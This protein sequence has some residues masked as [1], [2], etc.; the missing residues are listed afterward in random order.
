M[1]KTI[2]GMEATQAVSR[3]PLKHG[4]EPAKPLVEAV[5]SA[6][7]DLADAPKLPIDTEKFAAVSAHDGSM[8]E[9]TQRLKDN[10]NAPIP[11]CLKNLG[12]TS[13][14]QLIER[15]E[16][17]DDPS[18]RAPTP[19]ELRAKREAEKQVNKAKPVEKP[20]PAKSSETTAATEIDSNVD[21][22]P[23][24]TIEPDKTF[25]RILAQEHVARTALE[26][27]ELATKSSAKLN[28]GTDEP[29]VKPVED[30]ASNAVVAE[31][32]DVLQQYTFDTDTHDAD[33]RIIDEIDGAVQP[34]N[35]TVS[36]AVKIVDI[37]DP[38][39]TEAK[40][41]VKIDDTAHLETQ[42]HPVVDP[43][44][45][46]FEAENAAADTS[47]AVDEIMTKLGL[48]Y[49]EPNEE[50]VLEKSGLMAEVDTDNKVV[51]DPEWVVDGLGLDFE[52]LELDS[53][54]VLH[55][56]ELGSA[57]DINVSLRESAAELAETKAET[58]EPIDLLIELSSYIK[59]LEPAK[60][61][62]AETALKSLSEALEASYEKTD[63]G[64]ESSAIEMKVI[65]HIFVEL[66][67]A[68]NLDYE[69][70]T[71]KKLMQELF[72]PELLAWIT[73]DS[74]PSIDQLNYS[75]T[76]EYKLAS[77]TSLFSRLLQLIKQR[78]QPYL[79]LGNMLWRL[80]VAS[81]TTLTYI[82]T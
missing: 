39:E 43:S 65:E 26:I 20:N 28:V 14:E 6:P 40:R 73:E 67:E 50:D 48:E 18:Q 51:E 77:M 59:T 46:E 31:A 16:G 47:P 8:N 41:S 5:A 1:P 4:S 38:K 19:R 49:P 12:I 45:E 37:I 56:V 2:G 33:A 81:E 62:A 74:S 27:V 7:I 15:V 60:A 24:K 52:A 61:Q 17:T 3:K 11:Q 75:G 10:P 76:R 58:K 53:E 36:T 63:D 29:R 54:T 44:P 79:Q 21:R 42:I 55:E 64:D 34:H 25:E 35:Q 66:L 22:M 68:L 23:V 69:E 30:N 13:L 70:E 71:V 9:M 82:I 78:I 57:T 80:A 32:E 72:T